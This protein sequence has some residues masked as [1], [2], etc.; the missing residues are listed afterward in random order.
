MEPKE[1]F[2]AATTSPENRPSIESPDMPQKEIMAAKKAD[3]NFTQPVPPFN[4]GPPIL[5]DPQ[6]VG[7][8]AQTTAPATTLPKEKAADNDVIENTW[9]NQAENIITNEA[10][11]P[12]RLEEDHEDL[13]IKYLDARFAKKLEKGN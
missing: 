2:V 8:T 11:D 3:Q 10:Q 1:N 7:A 9:V 13:Q 5:S 12:Y 6:T 4:P